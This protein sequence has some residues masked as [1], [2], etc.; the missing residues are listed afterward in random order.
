MESNDER[1]PSSPDEPGIN[2]PYPLHVASLQPAILPADFVSQLL[3]IFHD[4]ELLCS[5]SD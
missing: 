3:K 5:Q 1:S 2:A 4:F